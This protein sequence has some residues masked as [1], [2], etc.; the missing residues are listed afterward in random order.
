MRNQKLSAIAQIVGGGTPKTGVDAYWD[1]GIV[2]LSPTD[3]PPIG[4]IA[5]ISDSVRRITDK[6]LRNSAARLLP[7][8]TVA[9]SSRA[10]IGKIGVSDCEFA[11]NQGFTNFI[12]HPE[13][14]PKFLAYALL[15]HTPAIERLSNSTTFKEITKSAFGDFEIGVPIR[16]R[17][18]QIVDILDQADALRRKRREANALHDRILPALFHR[19]F[20]DPTLRGNSHKFKPLAELGRITTG[21]TPPTSVP[22]LFDGDI[23]FVTPSDL[24]GSWIQ[25]SRT[26]SPAGAEQS[27]TVGRGATLVCCIGAT[28]GKIGKASRLSAFNQQINAIEWHEPYFESYGPE[29]M[30]I[31]KP[32][33]VAA[34][35]STTLPIV[36]KSTFSAFEIPVPDPKKATEFH[37]FV[38][39]H[40]ST[41]P[42]RQKATENLET[43][44]QTL[45]ARAFD[46]RL[47]PDNAA[48]ARNAR[49]ETDELLQEIE[50]QSKP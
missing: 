16:K 31:V 10:S 22:G 50:T 35:T 14:S 36:N 28:L 12:C 46:G 27:K 4:E 23:P 39:Q 9:Y 17:Q 25:H 45:L 38:I 42:K 3:L 32:L 30:K 19:M 44:F 26:V 7:S 47:F 41:H 15:Y 34:G 1:G 8:G 40:E 48:D 43:L 18:D 2:W 6:G 37:H 20:G 11:T 49:S 5:T 33:L 24:D 13:V 29:V 21:R